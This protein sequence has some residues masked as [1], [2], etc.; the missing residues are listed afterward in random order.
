M[1]VSLPP[2][3]LNTMRWAESSDEISIVSS[4]AS[5]SIVMVLRRRL[6]AEKSPMTL[7]VSPPARS[8]VPIG[9]TPL[10]RIS[11]I[12]RSSAMIVGRSRAVAGDHDLGRAH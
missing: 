6:V 8:V 3:D 2:L 11:S 4:P 10:M 9:S 12:S 7:K 1:M 5:P